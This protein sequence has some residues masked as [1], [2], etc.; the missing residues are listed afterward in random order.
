LTQYQRVTNGWT[1]RHAEYAK[2]DSPHEFL[3]VGVDYVIRQ[4]TLTRQE[5]RQREYDFL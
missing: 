3:F 1:N 4:L 2:I 5:S